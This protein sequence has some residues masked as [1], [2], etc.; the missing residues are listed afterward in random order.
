MSAFSFSFLVRYLSAYP[1]RP[2]KVGR[3]V[4]LYQRSFKYDSLLG[5]S[6][7]VLADLGVRQASRKMPKAVLCSYSVFPR[8]SASSSLTFGLHGLLCM[9]RSIATSRM[10][11]SGS[12]VPSPPSLRYPLIFH[13]LFSF[14]LSVV[15]FLSCPQSIS[16]PRALR[17]TPTKV[18]PAAVVLVRIRQIRCTSP[19]SLS[20]KQ[21][22]HSF[23]ANAFLDQAMSAHGRGQSARAFGG[24]S[25]VLDKLRCE[26][27]QR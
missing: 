24:P 25:A 21:S 7:E 5:G 19:R 20:R 2:F 18:Y 26:T 16:P 15:R 10:A 8:V 6:E 13:S 22:K 3:F 12:N 27:P 23:S 9:I 14:R 4:E 11:R 1:S 17:L